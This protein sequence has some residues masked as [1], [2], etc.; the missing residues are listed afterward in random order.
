MP[1]TPARRFFVESNPKIMSKT[2]DQNVEKAQVLVAGI[3]KNFAEVE[4]YGIRMENLAKLEEE[5]AKALA[6]I[7]EVE[8]LREIVS[9]KLQAA[10]AQLESV[11]GNYAEIRQAIRLNYPQEQWARFGLMDKR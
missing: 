4:K 7:R 3:K 11:K 1:C 5:S 2:F 8:E 9:Q 10:N 6:M